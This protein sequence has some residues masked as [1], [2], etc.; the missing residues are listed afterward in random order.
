MNAVNQQD[1]GKLNGQESDGGRQLSCDGREKE[2]FC[3]RGINNSL[4]NQ[5]L[6]KGDQKLAAGREDYNRD[7]ENQITLDT[8]ELLDSFKQ[9]ERRSRLSFKYLYIH[10]ANSLAVAL[11]IKIF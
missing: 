8:D 3:Q 4:P 9:R 7:I 2:K 11:N 1:E 10:G 6:I 5:L